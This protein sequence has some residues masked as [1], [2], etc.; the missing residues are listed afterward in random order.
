MMVLKFNSIQNY[1]YR[2][3]MQIMI[4]FIGLLTNTETKKERLLS[5]KNSINGKLLKIGTIEVLYLILYYLF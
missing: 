1:K 3:N 4:C 5:L 2:Y